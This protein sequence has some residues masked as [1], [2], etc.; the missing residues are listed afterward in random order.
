MRHIIGIYADA[1]GYG[2]MCVGVSNTGD[3]EIVSESCSAG[4]VS[5]VGIV[6]SIK[7]I[8]NTLARKGSKN[9][10]VHIN[11]LPTLEK[12]LN[13][14]GYYPKSKILN[15]EDRIITVNAYFADDKIKISE[16]LQLN[17][18]NELNN[19]DIDVVNHRVYALFIA[20]QDL[21]YRFPTLLYMGKTGTYY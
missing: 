11:A 7:T 1:K 9:I 15:I 13:Q 17:L 3:I 4:I 12:V 2:V 16:K 20:L 18:A 5:F 8:K 19:F 10:T 6:N 14:S 21:T